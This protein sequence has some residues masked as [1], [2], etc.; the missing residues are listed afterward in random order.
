MSEDTKESISYK[1]AWKRL[2]EFVGWRVSE[3]ART[4][5]YAGYVQI[6]DVQM[7]MD[8][9]NILLDTGNDEPLHD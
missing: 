1:E 9:L 4:T 2:S 7:E 5:N 3:V 8:R 6:S